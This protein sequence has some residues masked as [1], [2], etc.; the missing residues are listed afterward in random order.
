VIRP[1]SGDP[2]DIICGD[3]FAPS[4][5]PAYKGVAELLW[6]TFGGTLNEKG[7][8]QLDPHIGMIYG[9]SINYQRAVGMCKRLYDKGFVSTTCVL[10]IGSFNYQYVTRDTFGFAMK[11]TWAEIDGV[12][13]DLFKDP[14]TDDGVKKSAKGPL[15]VVEAE[16]G[17]IKL[18]DQATPHQEASDLLQTVWEDGKSKATT[19]HA[20][21]SFQQHARRPTGASFGVPPGGT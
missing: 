1:D 6:E 18:I 14:V 7:F 2:V 3:P 10:G 16:N 12:G 4:D 21:I 5:S 20:V 15:A 9:D 19:E 13:H 11:A 17:G 8:K